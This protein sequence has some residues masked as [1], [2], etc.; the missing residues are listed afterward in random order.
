[1][2]TETKATLMQKHYRQR[3][4][5]EYWA[6]RQLAKTET[7]FA[8]AALEAWFKHSQNCEA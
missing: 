8:R 3:A 6:K 7:Q 2:T 1:M 4:G 5:A